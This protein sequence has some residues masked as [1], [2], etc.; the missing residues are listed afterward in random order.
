MKYIRNILSSLF[1]ASMS[2]FAT[3]AYA[4]ES[5]D[6]SNTVAEEIIAAPQIKTLAHG[7]EI[8]ISDNNNHQIFVYALTGQIIKTIEVTPGATSIEL[9]AGYYIVKIDKLAKRVIIR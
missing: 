4:A 2:L 8:E 3:E 7:I 9:P 5:P 1:F 6:D